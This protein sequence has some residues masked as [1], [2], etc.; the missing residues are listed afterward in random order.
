MG[1]LRGTLEPLWRV[2]AYEKDLQFYLGAF[3]GNACWLHSLWWQAHGVNRPAAPAAPVECMLQFAGLAAAQ[4]LMRL[5]C[6]LPPPPGCAAFGWAV[7][8]CR[9]AVATA[10]CFCQNSCHAA[11]TRHMPPCCRPGLWCMPSCCPPLDCCR[12]PA[13]CRQ[14]LCGADPAQQRHPS[15]RGPLP[16]AGRQPAAAAAGA[17][18]HAGGALWGSVSLKSR[19][20]CNFGYVGRQG[21]GRCCWRT[22]LCR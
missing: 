1:A 10:S 7:P 19:R 12:A 6:M 21:A 16:R 9:T 3:C 11:G 8:R 4:H 18:V 17:R 5:E 22:R 13:L 2:P 15:V 20:S 14:G